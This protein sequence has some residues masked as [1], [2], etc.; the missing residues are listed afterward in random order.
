MLVEAETSHIKTFWT[1]SCD[2]D[3]RFYE[4]FVFVCPAHYEVII[5]EAIKK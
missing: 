1:I 4:P 2:V 3:Q 5:M